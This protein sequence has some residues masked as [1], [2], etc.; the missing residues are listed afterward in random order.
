MDIFKRKRGVENAALKNIEF[1]QTKEKKDASEKNWEKLAQK[2]IEENH[3]LVEKVKNPQWI[4]EYVDKHE[5]LGSLKK[6]LE[7]ACEKTGEEMHL[8]SRLIMDVYKKLQET[9]EE[10]RQDQEKQILEKRRRGE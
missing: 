8:D 2:M 3:P 9:E 7:L 6:N 1:D 4:K 5:N 10:E